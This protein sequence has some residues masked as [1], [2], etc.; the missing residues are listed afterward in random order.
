MSRTITI[1]ANNEA[2]ADQL[3]LITLA[4]L[5]FASGYVRAH[6]GVGNFVYNGNTFFGVGAYGGI[7]G[8]KEGSN[9]EAEKIT[10]TLSG[11]DPAYISIA[12]NEQYQG[13]PANFWIGFLNAT[14]Q[15]ITDPVLVFGGRIDTMNIQL[16]QVGEVT[17]SVIN[18]LADWAK[19]KVR[20]YNDSDQQSIF[21]G[22]LGMQYVERAAEKT[23]FWGRKAQ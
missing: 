18:K 15:L 1:A 11:V 21:P 10:A 22:D 9:L 8:V 14:E 19:P 13:R 3:K 5:S 16:G 20:R 7:S 4:E 12:L 2:K 17:I 23:L 6:S